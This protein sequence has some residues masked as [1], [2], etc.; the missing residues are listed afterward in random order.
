MTFHMPDWLGTMVYAI[1][2][3]IV[4]IKLPWITILIQ[5]LASWFAALLFH[6]IG[7]DFLQRLTASLPFSRRLVRY[8]NRA[9]RLVVLLLVLQVIL[10]NAPDTLAGISIMRHLSALTLIAALTWLG[11]RCVSAIADTIIEL[12]PA[13]APN[14]LRERRIQTQTKVLAHT[15]MVLL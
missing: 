11:V 6:R 13:H 14:N 10:R 12:N 1:M 2:P 3:W 8:G 15:L 4:I 5:I 9:G 7:T